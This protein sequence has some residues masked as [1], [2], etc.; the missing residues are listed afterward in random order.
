MSG[1]APRALEKLC[2]L[3][4]LSA[5]IVRPLNFT[6]SRHDASSRRSAGRNVLLELRYFLRGISLRSGCLAC[7]IRLVRSKCDH[8]HTRD[9]QRFFPCRVREAAHL[10]S[11]A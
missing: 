3:G 4:A 11:M 2:A 5:A 10:L 1:L 8:R 6:V 9:K 7:A